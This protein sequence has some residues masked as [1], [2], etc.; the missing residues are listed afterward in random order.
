MANQV[1]DPVASNLRTICEVHREIYDLI[2]QH[3]QDSPVYRDIV[4]RLHTAF[5]MAKRMNAK[6]RQYKNNY[7]DAW[8]EEEAREILKQKLELR[9]GRKD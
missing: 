3:H 6:L 2:H 4:E 9:Q 7:D 5:H 1:S 8:W